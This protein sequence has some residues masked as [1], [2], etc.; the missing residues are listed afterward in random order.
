LLLYSPSSPI[1]KNESSPIFST[2]GCGWSNPDYIPLMIAGAIIGNYDRTVGGGQN[3][4]SKL[5]QN[6]V[7][8][9]G[10]NP[11]EVHSFMSFNTC[12][13]DTGLWGVYAVLNNT[14]IDDFIYNLQ[15]EWRRLCFSVTEAE[16]ERA[17]KVFK[18]SLFMQL[19]GSTAVCEDIGRQMLTYGRRI[20]L[21]EIDYRI[22]VSTYY[23]CTV[24][25]Y[26]DV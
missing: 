17:K 20:P 4:A 22:Q 10:T 23:G 7:A 24:K 6:I 18:T 19:D 11:S 8:H 16:V 21:P 12:Y 25:V 14:S 3:M 9:S 2:Q 13:T 15:T 26:R 1:Q 5:A